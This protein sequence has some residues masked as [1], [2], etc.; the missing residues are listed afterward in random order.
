MKT[1]PLHLP[2]PLI[3]SRE[4]VAILPEAEYESLIETLQILSDQKLLQRI[5][6]ALAH[7]SKGR[8]FTHQEV[9]PHKP[10]G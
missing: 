10:N 5:E 7:L 8:F 9:F 4:P 3:K 2:K 1:I 6:S